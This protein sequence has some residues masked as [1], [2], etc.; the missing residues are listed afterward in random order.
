LTI[1]FPLVS[2]IIPTY[3]SAKTLKVCLDSVKLQTY[4]NIEVIVVD[5]FSR[6]NTRKIAKEYTSKVLIKGPERSSQRNFAEKEANGEYIFFIDSD[7][8]LDRNVVAECVRV[9]INTR[10]E[11]LIIPEFSIGDNFWAKIKAL[12]RSVAQGDMLYEAARF[13]KRQTFEK[14]NGYDKDIT[15]FE[16]FDLQARMEEQNMVVSRASAWIIHFEGNAS[17]GRHLM[18]KYYYFSNS[19][20]YLKNH[21]WKARRQL[22][23]A[24]RYLLH[25]TIVVS[26]PLYLMGLIFLKGCEAIISIIGAISANDP[27]TK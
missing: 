18:K 25:L 22:N 6:D 24:R 21:P 14:L 2:V 7:M 10:A 5:N 16:D 3:N 20:K 11:G 27:S 23:P 4:K 17:L 15:G 12:D 13:F 8:K 9:A 26:D 19:K 1:Y